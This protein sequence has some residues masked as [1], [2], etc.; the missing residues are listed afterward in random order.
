MRRHHRC[1]CHTL[2]Y[3]GHQKYTPAQCCAGSCNPPETSY[4]SCTRPA[5]LS[6]HPHTRARA[7]RRRSCNSSAHLCAL[8]CALAPS[9][10]PSERHPLQ[11]TVRSPGARRCASGRVIPAPGGHLNPWMLVAPSTTPASSTSRC[12]LPSLAHPL[13]APPRRA[14]TRTLIAPTRRSQLQLPLCPGI[15][16]WAPSS[17]REGPPCILFCFVAGG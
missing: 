5:P 2:G 8:P 15:V 10:T 4:P 3:S 1:R 13:Q 17:W 9:H 12:A 7:A 16:A 11:L 14:R 6:S